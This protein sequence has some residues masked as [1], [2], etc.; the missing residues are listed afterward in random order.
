[1]SKIIEFKTDFKSTPDYKEEIVLTLRKI[2]E[3]EIELSTAIINLAAKGKW[4]NWSDSIPTGEFFTFTEEMLKD[5]GD[6]NIDDL[7]FLMDELIRAKAK[8]ETR[9]VGKI[10]F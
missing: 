2:E 9:F 1:M 8:I 3:I 6:E 7:T 5:T 10:G 4:M